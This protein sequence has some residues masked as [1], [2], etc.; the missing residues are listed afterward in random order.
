MGAAIPKWVGRPAAPSRVLVFAITIASLE[1]GA[2]DE[3]PRFHHAARRRGGRLAAGGAGGSS[4]V[5]SPFRVATPLVPGERPG[6]PP[7]GGD[8]TERAQAEW[9]AGNTTRRGRGP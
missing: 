9:I 4:Q 1:P 5:G 7:V 3:T 2:A 6:F 8:L